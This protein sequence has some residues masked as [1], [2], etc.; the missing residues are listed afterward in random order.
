[1][2]SR[3]PAYF[4][5]RPLPATVKSDGAFALAPRCVT[6]PVSFAGSA[7]QPTAVAS[8]LVRAAILTGVARSWFQESCS[9][10][11]VAAHPFSKTRE[12]GEIP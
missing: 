9:G 6:P 1:M 8:C 10:E 4:M 2:M 11:I 5:L 7:S 3:V 12:E